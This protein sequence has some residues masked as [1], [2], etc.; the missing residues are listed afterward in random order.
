MSQFSIAGHRRLVVFDVPDAAA[1]ASALQDA[2]PTDSFEFAPDWN[3]TAGEFIS[4]VPVWY[5]PWPYSV[6]EEQA[7][8]VL[9]LFVH[10]LIASQHAFCIAFP[11]SRSYFEPQS[12]AIDSMKLLDVEDIGALLLSDAVSTSFPLLK[13]LRDQVIQTP[14]E[15]QLGRAMTE[16]GILARPQVRF[17]PYIPDF[18]IEVENRRIVV[19]ADGAGFHDPEKDRMRDAA[20]RE[21]G[22]DFVIRFTGREIYRDASGCATRVAAEID[23][24]R[25]S[26]TRPSLTEHDFRNLDDSQRRAVTHPGGAARVLAPAGSGKTTTMV[27][28]VLLLLEQGADLSSILVLAFN[29]KAADQLIDRLMRQGVPLRHSILADD[30]PGVLV[31]TFNAF[32][33]RYQ[34]QIVQSTLEL[35]TGRASWRQMMERAL[36]DHG[37]TTSS[38][39]ARRG[40]DP[41]GQFLTALARTRADLQPPSEIS[42]EIDSYES[43]TNPIIPFDKVYESFSRRQMDARWQSFDDQ[44]FLTVRDLLEVPDHRHIMQR[45]FDYVLVDEFQDLNGSQMALV[46][47]LSRP[48]R[49]LYVVGDDDQM[50]YGWR[51]AKLDNI[52]NFH[53]RMPT[54]PLSVT[55]TLNT[56]YRCSR[57]V[58]E[59][60]RRLIDHNL[61]RVPKDIQAAPTAPD[62]HVQYFGSADWSERAEEICRFLRDE[63]EQHDC[64]WAELAVLC[65]YKA[66]Q[67][68]IAMALDQAGIPRTALLTYRL[69]THPAAELLRSYLRLVV[70]PQSLMGDDVK[71][72][73][74]R[75][76][77][78]VKNELVQTIA[79]TPDPW[80]AISARASEVDPPKGLHDLYRGVLHLQEQLAANRLNSHQ[81]IAE[82]VAIFGLE[83]YWKDESKRPSDTEQDDAG[84]LHVLSAVLMLADDSESIEELLLTWDNRAML[85]EAQQDSDERKMSDDDLKREESPDSDEVVIG[86]MHA[87]KGRE[88]RSVVLADYYP[89][90]SR[91]S[92]EEKEEER[93]VLYVGVTRAK[94]SILVTLD[95]S[96][97]INPLIRE[98]VAP[99]LPN[100]PDLLSREMYELRDTEGDLVVALARE[101][102]KIAAIHSGAEV[103]R[104][105]TLLANLHASHADVEQS[106]AELTPYERPRGIGGFIASLTSS[107]ERSARE[108]EERK[109][110]LIT[111]RDTL[112]KQI[113]E[114]DDWL[115]L[116]RA[117]PDVA[118][119]RFAESLGE[120]EADLNLNRTRQAELRS[121]LSELK[122]FFS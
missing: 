107:A 78:Y 88:Y 26:D 98:L 84:P 14:I 91:M 43:M 74:N 111:K 83:Q 103:E 18:L 80:Q 92:N 50:I 34:Q 4:G 65:R 58:V 40:S 81:L 106:L 90:L 93:H 23:A 89:D 8:S 71:A 110:A 99:P 41:V 1:L 108:Q 63:R 37:I 54:E 2:F 17:G 82:S 66:Q 118:T 109:N 52:L 122:L 115:V 10:P 70:Q 112:S 113:A 6:F 46:D 11:W 87:S 44:I 38:L 25:S 64:K 9:R 42:V 120:A 116:L 79:M 57:A 105:M 20:L 85:E 101:Q 35:K 56:N 33:Y 22:I 28:R 97:Q 61:R 47:I 121:R 27:Q 55:Y 15:E 68:I 3:W 96:K 62:G 53:D 45:L 77:R 7:N 59:S 69:F 36:R 102:G 39:K 60:S 119:R 24:Q 67:P 48:A 73:M 94:H 31:V 95:S 72:L 5:W 19:E 12:L 117:D 76:N 104:S 21:M 114:I 29:K 86:T 16:A 30:Q 100:E 32:G 49:N 51:F 13:Q 75:P